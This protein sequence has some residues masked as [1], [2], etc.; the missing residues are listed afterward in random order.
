[1]LERGKI[2]QLECASGVL[3]VLAGV[4]EDKGVGGRERIRLKNETNTVP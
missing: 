1:M 4:W 2:L 3:P